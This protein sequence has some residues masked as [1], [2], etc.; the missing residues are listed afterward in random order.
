M[1]ELHYWIE[2]TRHVLASI[3]TMEEAH[4]LKKW[5]YEEQKAHHIQLVHPKGRVDC[6]HKR[7]KMSPAFTA[8]SYRE[9]I[10]GLR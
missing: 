4:E 5:L 1:F 6:F 3:P 8:K 9:G 10:Y 2:K 7:G